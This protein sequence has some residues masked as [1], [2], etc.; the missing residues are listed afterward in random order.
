MLVELQE[1]REGEDELPERQDQRRHL[2]EKRLPARHQHQQHA[3][4]QR[5]Q[6]QRTQNRKGLVHLLGTSRFLSHQPS[7]KHRYHD[8]IANDDDRADDD[9]EG[10]LL[11]VAGLDLPQS[12]ARPLHRIRR[13]VDQP[14]DDPAVRHLE[15]EAAQPSGCPGRT[16]NRTAHPQNIYCTP[17]GRGGRTAP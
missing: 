7:L 14:L 17:T 10:V 15:E 16:Q 5:Q 13:P 11:D 2:Y 3:A 12:A 4:G 6:D 1:E 8:K 9:R